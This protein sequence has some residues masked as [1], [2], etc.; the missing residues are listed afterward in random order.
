MTKSRGPALRVDQLF[1]LHI[2]ERAL[3]EVCW[4]K[5]KFE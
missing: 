3:E 2:G 5:M 4:T 1:Y